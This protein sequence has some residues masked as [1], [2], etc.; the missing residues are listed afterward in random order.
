M[1]NQSPAH[2]A[3]AS[4]LAAHHGQDLLGGGDVVPGLEVHMITVEPEPPRELSDVGYQ[5]VSAAHDALTMNLSVMPAQALLIW[6]IFGV[7]AVAVK[8]PRPTWWQAGRLQSQQPGIS[9]PAQRCVISGS[10]SGLT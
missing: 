5:A 1:G 6:V 2:E 10:Q 3:A 7:L 8:L 9:T 4:V